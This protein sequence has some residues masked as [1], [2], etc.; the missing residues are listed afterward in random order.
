MCGG[1][2]FQVKWSRWGQG[3]PERNSQRERGRRS[4]HLGPGADPT[5]CSW[6]WHFQLPLLV[7]FAGV[8]IPT[9]WPSTAALGSGA[10][11]HLQE[12]GNS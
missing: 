2:H 8:F 5:N 4:G 11:V 12:D 6:V 3:R 10:L 1:A 7:S 9:T